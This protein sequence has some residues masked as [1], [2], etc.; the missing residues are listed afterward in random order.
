M[1]SFK[2]LLRYLRPY[3]MRV[4]LAVVLMFAVT[5]SA[6]P[7]PLLQKQVLDVAIPNRDVRMLV[8]IFAGVLT[9][10]AVRGI[11]SYTLNYL[12]GWLGQRVI[13]DLRYQS[14]RHLQR[15]SLA[16][17][18]GRQPGKIMSRLTTDIDV[19]QYALTS[20]FV[21]FIT[22]LATVVIIVG[23]LFYLEWRL[24][25]L[26]ISVV[27]LY[28]LNYK[29]LLRR[30]R[31][32]SVAL[33]EKRE[34]MIGNLS[35]K[36]NAIAVVKAF[37]RE[38]HETDY[39]MH[40]IRENF[41]LGMEQTKLN[42]FLGSTSQV[43]RTLG[44]ASMLW[45]GGSLA[46]QRQLT[47]GELFAFH[48]YIGYLYDPTV[49]LV[50]FNVQVQWAL[51]AIERVFETLDTRPEIV[52]ATNA[53]HL[54]TV[55]GSVEYRNVTFGYDSSQ[56][57]LKNVTFKVEAGETIAIVGPS[58]AGKTTVVN[59]LARFYDVNEGQ[60]LVDGHDVRQ[61][62]LESMRRHIGMVS[63][64][65]ILFSVSL[66]ENIRY[67]KRDATDEQVIAAAKAADMH[68]FIMD[69]PDGYETKIG[70]DGIKLSG[71]QKQRMAIARAIL[72]DP[73]I[74]ILDDA[75]SALDSHT[76]A[77]VQAAL[78]VLMQGRTNFVIA[79]RLSTIMSADRILVMNEGRIVDFGTHQDLVGRPGIY[80][81]L[82]NEQFKTVGELSEEERSR[83]LTV[84]P[85]ARNN[86]TVA[87]RAAAG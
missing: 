41:A 73:R 54:T 46:L 47:V 23:W 84:A 15:L 17:Y 51:A 26:A 80:R 66:K 63:Q 67:G 53:V 82:Y 49:R 22:D 30:I 57:V 85:E 69:L 2:R 59:L 45:F 33:R 86:L 35:E 31:D 18:D 14:Y 42:R 7:M 24:A 1:D 77:N 81:D 65:T 60:V 3:R 28:V 21:N 37:V 38:D 74:L 29:L 13:F 39:T 19:I 52:D 25:L 71:G 64:E 32:V 56:P 61:V 76:E 79:H 16:Y 11:V 44:T 75:T 40:T 48:G 58:G 87:G 34:I 20:G 50:D 8:W 9:L 78:A 27:P 55:K 6:I 10:Y 12:I 43:I 68:D 70:E 36:L 83:L 62:R 72:A 4:A 5:L